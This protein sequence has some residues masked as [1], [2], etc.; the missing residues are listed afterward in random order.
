MEAESEPT[1]D[2][3]L[4]VLLDYLKRTRGFDFTGYER[5]SLERR[6]AKRMQE[7]EIGSHLEY[8]DYLE[9]HP[10]EF[11][12]LFNTILINVTSFFRDVEVWD[13]LRAT[14]LGELTKDNGPIRVWSAGC[15][16]GQEAYTAAI[17]L[18]E[19]L[20]LNAFR[21]SKM[22]M[23]DPKAELQGWWYPYSDAF[24]KERGGDKLG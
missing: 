14:V 16:S 8:L 24:F 9:V 5:T 7:V 3:P 12:F 15:A 20:G 11:A 2:A 19:Q 21:Q 17:V 13:T 4:D 18:A 6:I 22:V 1:L 23:L 10:D